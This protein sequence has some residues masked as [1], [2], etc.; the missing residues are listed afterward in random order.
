MSNFAK[1]KVI[2]KNED[3]ET[4]TL[5]SLSKKM[6]LF[7]CVFYLLILDLSGSRFEAGPQLKD[8]GEA[9]LDEAAAPGATPPG[10][11]AGGRPPP[12]RE[13]TGWR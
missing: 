11:A 12:L 5:A 13:W 4:L 7:K 8:S 1:T 9:D 2:R 6:H 3:I 10:A